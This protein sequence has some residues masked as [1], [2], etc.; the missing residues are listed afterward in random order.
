MPYNTVKVSNFF[1]YATFETNELQTNEFL[2][3]YLNLYNF[4]SIHLI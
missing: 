4:V 2:N 3:L 1:K